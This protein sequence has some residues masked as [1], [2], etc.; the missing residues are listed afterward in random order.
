[1]ARPY[2]YRT[3]LKPA[4]RLVAELRPTGVDVPQRPTRFF[5]SNRAHGLKAM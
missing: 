3:G 4:Q 2:P 1:M 5:A